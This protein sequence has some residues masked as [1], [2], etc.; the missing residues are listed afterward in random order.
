VP[1]T[2]IGALIALLLAPG[3][4][5]VR[6]YE[7]RRL[8]T[9]PD[10]DIYALAEAIVA[11]AI[12]LGLAWLVVTKIFDVN[13]RRIGILPADQAVLGRHPIEVIGLALAVVLVPYPLGVLAAWVADRIDGSRTPRVVRFKRR[14]RRFGFF[15][16]PTAWDEMWTRA[17]NA[18]R[19]HV[20]LKL[21]DGSYVVG[22]YG[23]PGRA[24]VSPAATRGVYL[25]RAHAQVDPSFS[26]GL[27][28]LLNLDENYEAVLKD[29]G[30]HPIVDEVGVFVD[31]DE[32]LAAFVRRA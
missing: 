31:G 28:L 9:P 5:L 17:Q 11:S 18:G 23:R 27:S 2:A 24:D 32:V 13:L 6:G 4:L 30:F 16:V 29:P 14:A 19:A 8:H 3:F 15:A 22:G 10:R 25:S 7:R 20:V 12:W 1:A 26:G 21:K